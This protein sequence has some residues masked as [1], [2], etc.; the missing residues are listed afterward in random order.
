ML[1]SPYGLI[2]LFKICF[3][4]ADFGNRRAVWAE[5]FALIVAW[6]GQM[7]MTPCLLLHPYAEKCGFESSLTW[8][9]KTVISKKH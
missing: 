8:P 4:A 6:Q 3:G 2:S 1:F 5:S 9:V 7:L